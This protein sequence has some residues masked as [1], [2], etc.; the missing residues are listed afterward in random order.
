MYTGALAAFFNKFSAESL[1]RSAAVDI[2]SIFSIRFGNEQELSS[3]GQQISLASVDFPQPSSQLVPSD[4]VSA[5]PA[6]SDS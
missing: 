2:G 1:E 5:V 4:C 6:D 3:G